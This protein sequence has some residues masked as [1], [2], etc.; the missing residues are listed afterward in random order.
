MASWSSIRGKSSLCGGGQEGVSK[1]S[2]QC[3]LISQEDKSDFGGEG[4]TWLPVEPNATK[5]TIWCA[6][7]RLTVF[8][9][10]EVF[11]SGKETVLE[12][13]V[14]SESFF[15]F[16]RATLSLCEVIVAASKSSPFKFAFLGQV[17]STKPRR[18][19]A[20]KNGLV[21]LSRVGL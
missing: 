11:S 17:Q 2:L 18:G 20:L 4:T 21:F 5:R 10:L 16:L 6:K 3:S 15:S 19:T 8:R 1:K 14:L 7:M 12:S 13:V 9:K